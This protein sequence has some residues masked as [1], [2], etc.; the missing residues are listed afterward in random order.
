MGREDRSQQRHPR[1]PDARA[2]GSSSAGVRWSDRIG[3]RFPTTSRP[4]PDRWPVAA[5]SASGFVACGSGKESSVARS[6]S[7]STLISVSADT[8]A[9]CQDRQQLKAGVTDRTMT[10]QDEKVKLDD[11][12]SRGQY[13]APVLRTAV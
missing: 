5:W 3:P 8:K 10:S 4:A 1:W 6:S 7:S 12:H 2:R 11:M 9:I 13:V